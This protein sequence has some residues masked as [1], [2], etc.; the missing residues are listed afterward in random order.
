VFTTDEVAAIWKA[1]YRQEA[2][3]GARLAAQNRQ[4]LA[5]EFFSD[6]FLATAPANRNVYVY[7]AANGILLGS[8]SAGS[9]ASNATLEGI[10]TDGTDVWIVDSR[11]DTGDGHSS[12]PAP[13]AY[14]RRKSPG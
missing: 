6:T 1:T 13:A 8:W 5:A 14:R 4:H 3:T 7:N 12:T 9:M 10:A 2:S 11:T